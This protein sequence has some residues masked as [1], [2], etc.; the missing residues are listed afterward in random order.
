MG[1]PEH[2]AASQLKCGVPDTVSLERRPAPVVRVA[3]QLD[4]EPPVWPEGVHLLAGDPDVYGGAGETRPP[5]RARGSVARARSASPALW[6]PR[7]PGVRVGP[8]SRGGRGFGRTAL[9]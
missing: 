2:S 3:V 9:R 4:H 7:R 1:N 6:G 8:A 5:G